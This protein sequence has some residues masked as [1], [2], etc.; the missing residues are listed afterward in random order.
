MSAHLL[1]P[2]KPLAFRR[3]SSETATSLE[4]S[5]RRPTVVAPPELLDQ[6]SDAHEVATM[7]ELA[8]RE[9]DE[10]ESPSLETPPETTV[11]DRYAF[12][13]DIDGVLIRG[14]RPIP[15]A[16]EAI[17]MLNGQNSFGIKV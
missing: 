8:R 10:N 6:P 7:M 3:L 2:A 13:F 4:L 14:G 12:A 15:E 5:S 17:K 16:I 11:T 9:M 1:A